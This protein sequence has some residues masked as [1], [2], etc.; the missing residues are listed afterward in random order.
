MGVRKRGGRGEKGGG[1]ISRTKVR[2]VIRLSLKTLRDFR[3]GQKR[4]QKNGEGA[5]RRG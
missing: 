5:G 4:E 3:M 2:I 1:G